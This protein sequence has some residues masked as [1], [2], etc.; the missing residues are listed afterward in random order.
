MIETTNL[1]EIDLG[2]KNFEEA[3]DDLEGELRIDPFIICPSVTRFQFRMLDFN[4]LDA[5]NRVLKPFMKA[6]RMPKLERLSVSI[7][8]YDGEVFVF[9]CQPSGSVLHLLP[10]LMRIIFPYPVYHKL[11]TSL[12]V[13]LSLLELEGTEAFDKRDCVVIDIPLN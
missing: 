12:A 8:P 9:L 2:L 1:T 7:E 6:I 11:F 10:H 5:I 13:K 4:S 3:A